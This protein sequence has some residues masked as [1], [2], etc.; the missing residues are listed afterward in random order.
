MARLRAIG[1]DDRLTLVDHLDELRTRLLVCIGVV[2]A[3][4]AVCFWQNELILQIAN[5]PLPVVDGDP[6][7]PATFSPTEALTTTLMLSVYAGIVISF[8]VWLWQL[9]AFLIPAVAPQER[10]VVLPLLAVVPV[11]FAA[12]VAFAYF[13]IVPA[14]VTFLLGFNADQFNIQLRAR[15]WYGFLGMV[16]VAMGVLWQMPMVLMSIT[17]MGIVTPDQLAGNR[18][19]AVLVIAVVAM[20]LPTQDPVTM[21]LEMVPLLVLY[22]VSILLSRIVARRRRTDEADPAFDDGLAPE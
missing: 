1:Y 6:I 14:A 3:A 18:R 20:L 11:L 13:V 21:L 8:P 7:V 2:V 5:R 16:L 9:Y 4:T 22:E 10:S 15:E 19:Y 17:R 12:G